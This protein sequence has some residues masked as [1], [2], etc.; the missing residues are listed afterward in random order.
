M[1]LSRKMEMETKA[2]GNEPTEFQ[3]KVHAIRCV[4]YK[5]YTERTQE[6]QTEIQEIHLIRKLIQLTGM[7][8]SITL[9]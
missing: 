5:T 9:Y 6:S 7:E 3:A 1:I 4:L 8:N 2:L